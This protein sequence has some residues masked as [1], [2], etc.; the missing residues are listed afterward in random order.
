MS[1][2]HRFAFLFSSLSLLTAIIFSLALAS[3]VS[4]PSDDTDFA[5]AIRQGIWKCA[6]DI[7]LK[8]KGTELHH[9]FDTESRLIQKELA[10]L[11]LIL[12]S[13]LP[14]SSITPAFQWAQSVN[15]VFLSVKFSHK[16]DAP[17][18][19]NVEA[20]NVNLTEKALLLEASDGRKLFKLSFSFYG[21]I[22]PEESIWSMVS[23]NI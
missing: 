9:V 3:D 8:S 2:Q 23:T 7:A 13:N 15:E 12:D 14:Q 16:L 1:R 11:K 20:T 4:C 21:P 6:K 22:I 10:D 19:L 18:T 17:A 5:T